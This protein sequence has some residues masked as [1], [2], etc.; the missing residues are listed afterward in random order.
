MIKGMVINYGEGLGQV[1]PRYKK[2]CVENVL[3]PTGSEEREVLGVRSIPVAILPSCQNM[4]TMDIGYCRVVKI[5]NTSRQY[6][7][8]NIP[9]GHHTDRGPMGLGQ[10]DGLGE[11]CGPHTASSVFLILLA[12]L[13]GRGW[14]VQKVLRFLLPRGNT[15][16]V[17]TILKRGGRSTK[18]FHPLSLNPVW[19]G[20]AKK[21]SN[22]I[23]P[24]PPCY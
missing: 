7:G 17:L 6:S 24:T 20:G 21:V 18:R 12:M 10:Y 3:L 19:K 4:K 2:G 23:A 16:I 1:L 8:H 11:Y 15:C 13:Q 22:F 9:L 14:E 5:R